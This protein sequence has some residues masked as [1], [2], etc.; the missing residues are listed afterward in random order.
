MA[1]EYTTSQ[2]LDLLDKNRT[3]TF[4]RPNYDELYISLDGSY[5]ILKQK[6]TIGV[7]LGD[8]NSQTRWKMK[9]S[10][11]GISAASEAFK[12]GKNIRCEFIGTVK[13]TPQVRH[14]KQGMSD[15]FGVMSH[16]AELITFYMINVGKWYID[17]EE[18]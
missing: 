10:N 9:Q 17:E 4:I 18:E 16:D 15:E 12:Q 13:G 2:A 8:C 1:K 5:R 14:W 6:Q 3:L 11:I 7:L